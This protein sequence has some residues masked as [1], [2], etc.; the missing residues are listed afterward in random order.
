MVRPLFLPGQD[1]ILPQN[2]FVSITEKVRANSFVSLN[3]LSTGRNAF[4]ING[5]GFEERS[6]AKTFSGAI[7]VQCAYEEIRYYARDKVV[8]GLPYL[9]S[10]NVFTSKGNGG[11]GLLTDGKAVAIIGKAF[12][13]EPGMACT[14]SL[15][16]FGQFRSKVQAERLKQYMATKFLR[17]LVGVLKVSQNLYQNVYAFVPLQ[18]FSSKSDIDWSKSVAEI[19]QQLYKKYKLTKPEIDFIES[20]ITSME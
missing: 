5:K 11:A 20:M 10:W 17:F 2:K 3:T 4:G 15:I 7:K 8:K 18:D 19:D 12:V 16:P 6:K 13:A 14:D 1:I 9:D